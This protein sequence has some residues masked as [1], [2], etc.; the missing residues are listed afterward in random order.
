MHFYDAAL[1]AEE[2]MTRLEW[3]FYACL[4][5]ALV[6]HLQ[7]ALDAIYLGLTRAWRHPKEGAGPCW[8]TSLSL[9]GLETCAHTRRLKGCIVGVYAATPSHCWT[10][11]PLMNQL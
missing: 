9:V 5:A 6:P 7:A 1:A 11:G 2:A 8:V 3:A 4:H 10:I